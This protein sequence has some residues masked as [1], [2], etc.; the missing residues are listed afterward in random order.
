MEVLLSK[1]K[2]FHVP[3]KQHPVWYNIIWIKHFCYF[4]LWQLTMSYY[5]FNNVSKY[6]LQE[7]YHSVEVP[8]TIQN[9]RIYTQKMLNCKEKILYIHIYINILIYSLPN[10]HSCK[11]KWKGTYLSRYCLIH[12]NTSFRRHLL[13]Q[14]LKQNAE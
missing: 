2:S 11:K 3:W 5:N 6:I 1:Y 9:W 13:Q 12:R 14:T 7:Y 4:T 8:P 10:S